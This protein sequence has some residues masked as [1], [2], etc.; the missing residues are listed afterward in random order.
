MGP[1]RLNSGGNVVGSDRTVFSIPKGAAAV[2]SRAASEAPTVADALEE[3][4]RMVRR[5]SAASA[6]D[7]RDEAEVEAED[8]ALIETMRRLSPD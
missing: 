8:E 7:E 2:G 5:R 6:G 3:F 1:T 4:E